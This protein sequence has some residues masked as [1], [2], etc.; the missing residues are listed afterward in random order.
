MPLSEIDAGWTHKYE[1]FN[2][3][4]SSARTAPILVKNQSIAEVSTASTRSHPAH[5]RRQHEGNEGNTN[6][7]RM[8]HDGT[9]CLHD[10]VLRDGA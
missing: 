3:V 5:T 4:R 2:F 10:V 1:N 8:L 9:R 6:D 7:T